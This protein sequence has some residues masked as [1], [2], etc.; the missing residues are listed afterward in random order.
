MAGDALGNV[1]ECESAG[2]FRHPRVKYDL[3]QKVAEFV[4]GS[5]LELGFD[6]V[7]EAME[8]EAT[9]RRYARTPEQMAVL[10]AVAGCAS[11]ALGLGASMIW[12]LPSGPAVVAAAAALFLL[13]TLFPAPRLAARPIR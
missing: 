5:L 8:Y 4:Q 9:A 13:V 7:V 2:L 10:A 12:N 11:V 3:Q 6:Y 1:V